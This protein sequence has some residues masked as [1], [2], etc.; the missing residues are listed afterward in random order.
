MNKKDRVDISIIIPVF[1]KA[2]SLH[3]C[4]QTL[5]N[6]QG[7]CSFEAIFIDDGSTD[8]SNDLCKA[9]VSSHSWARLITQKNQGVSSARNVGIDS[10]TGKYL[11]FLD[12]DD[13]L[14]DKAIAHLVD[15]FN[16]HYE[17]IDVVSYPIVYVDSK[18]RE[19]RHARE[20]WLNEDGVYELNEYPYIAQTTMNVCVK[21]RFEKNIHFEKNIKMGED[22][23]YITNNLYR[24]SRIGTCTTALYY[25]TRDGSGMSTKR[26]N[27]LYAF[28]DMVTLFTKLTEIA[29]LN[30]RMSEYAYQIIIYNIAWRLKSNMLFP[31][32]LEG[33]A[34]SHAK[35]KLYSLIEMIPFNSIITSPFMN[36]YHKGY[37]LKEF[38]HFD[39]CKYIDFSNETTMCFDEEHCWTVQ[40]PKIVITKALLR[41]SFLHIEG[42]IISP[43][44]I[45]IQKP[46]LFYSSEGKI[47]ECS[48]SKS[49]FDY[50]GSKVKTAKCWT[51]RIIVP[52]TTFTTYNFFLKTQ[53]GNTDNVSITLKNAFRFN[54]RKES[55]A[56]YFPDFVVSK[57]DNCIQLSKKTIRNSFK[58]FIHGFKRDKTAW[59]KRIALKSFR[60]LY[61]KE[62]I[63]LYSDLPTSQIGGNALIQLEHDLKKNDSVKRFYIT[64]DIDSFIQQHPALRHNVIQRGSKKHFFMAL[65]ARIILAS[66][67]ERFTF[68]PF[69]KRTYSSLGDIA[70]DQWYIYLQHGILHAHLPWYYSFDRII[71]DKEIV[72]SAFEETN[73]LTNYSFPKSALI[74][75][76]MPRFDTLRLI[77]PSC[78]KILYV[79][80]WRNYLIAGTGAKRI[81]TD[82]ALLTSSFYE[83][84]NQTLKNK[85]LLDLLEQYD[86]Q[87]DVKLHPNFKCYEHLIDINS[88]RVHNITTSINENDYSIVITDFSSYVFDFVYKG[89]SIIY[90]LPDYIEFNAGLNHYRELDLPLEKGFGPFCKSGEELIKELENL[91]KKN[92]SNKIYQDRINDFF[93]YRDNCNSERLYNDL[94]QLK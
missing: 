72:S 92:S 24:H 86:Y 88:A 67:L 41:D 89:C 46:Q 14:S 57:S 16:L 30:S 55:G 71:F 43:A 52:A 51:I 23:I 82:E 37:L 1:N 90:Y 87:L 8:A 94:K 85:T 56:L 93:F 39:A 69:K 42:R 79:P 38:L 61:R 6:Q 62:E 4:F 19:T 26:N 28:D 15:F 32:H 53:F 60:F 9:F 66:Y 13:S 64:S 12:A 29:K 20:Q 44:F 83:G 5:E 35:Q 22:Q 21:N 58:E 2:D 40:K 75:S 70:G 91:L 63:W 7:Q 25:Y 33:D 65:T 54:A 17:E 78:K 48:L 36:N 18:N 74:Q 47:K 27:P 45:F 84:F 31:F 81:P 49:S 59:L 3:K 11:L 77:K 34:L 68:L 76:G 80:S 73:L 50:S 10:S